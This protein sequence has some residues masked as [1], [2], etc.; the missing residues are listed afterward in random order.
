[1]NIIDAAHR[2]GHE[3]PGG[4]G[5]LAVRMGIGHAV[6]NSK[7]NPNTATHHLTLVE[8]VRMQ[9]ITGQFEILQAMAS[10]LGHVAIPLPTVAD[11]EISRAIAHTCAEFGDYMRQVDTSLLDGHVTA[12]EKKRLEKELTELISAATG[13]LALM[14][15]KP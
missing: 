2:M 5:A 3:F 9:Q 8:S 12:N 4:A 14:A 7:L 10:E 1:M 11:G 6:F 15:G 13:L